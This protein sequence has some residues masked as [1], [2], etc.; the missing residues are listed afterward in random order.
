MA[1]KAL[2]KHPPDNIDDCGLPGQHIG[3]VKG[4]QQRW[5]GRREALHEAGAGGRARQGLLLRLWDGV[6]Q[7]LRLLPPAKVLVR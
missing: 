5:A 1:G 4:L 7:H 3:S 6:T 2:G